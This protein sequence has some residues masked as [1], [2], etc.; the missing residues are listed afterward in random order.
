MG[1]QTSSVPFASPPSPVCLVVLEFTRKEDRDEEF[2]EGALNCDDC[3]KSQYSMRRVEFFEVP[4]QTRVSPKL[5]Q[6]V[7]CLRK[8][9]TRR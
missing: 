2:A 6:S 9:Q 1:P 7:K 8:I 3:G 4:L 5:D